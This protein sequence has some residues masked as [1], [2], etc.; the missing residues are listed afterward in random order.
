MLTSNELCKLSREISVY[1]N[2]NLLVL[3]YQSLRHLCRSCFKN[4]SL[5]TSSTLF[6]LSFKIK[7]HYFMHS[8]FGMVIN[9]WVSF[10]GFDFIFLDSKHLIGTENIHLSINGIHDVINSMQVEE[11]KEFSVFRFALSKE[12]RKVIIACQHRN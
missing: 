7:M 6:T 3:G 1:K 4:S 5:L 2:Q 8:S 11:R 10:L 12:R 9:W